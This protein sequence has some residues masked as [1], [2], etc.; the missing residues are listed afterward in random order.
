MSCHLGLITLS[1]TSTLIHEKST[2]FVLQALRPFQLSSM[3]PIRSSTAPPV[4]D[5]KS[6]LIHSTQNVKKLQKYARRACRK[7][8]KQQESIKLLNHRTTQ[9]LIQAQRDLDLQQ[10]YNQTLHHHIETAHKK[11]NNLHMDLKDEESFVQ[12]RQASE[13]TLTLRLADVEGNSDVARLSLVASEKEIEGIKEKLDKNLAEMIKGVTC[14]TCLGTMKS[15]VQIE[16]CGHSFCSPCLFKMFYSVERRRC[17]LCRIIVTHR[18]RPD[19]RIQNIANA[20]LEPVRQDDRQ[21]EYLGPCSWKNL[22][23]DDDSVQTGN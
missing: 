18:P 16:E 13:R 6:F 23:P 9:Q 22:F 15:A 14:D 17:P 8:K 3:A 7:T 5:T 4:V 1:F 12:Q 20:I 2:S 11:I 21:I 10:E 19:V